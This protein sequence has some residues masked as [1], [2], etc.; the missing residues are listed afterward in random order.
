MNADKAAQAEQIFADA[1]ERAADTRAAYLDRLCAGDDELRAEVDAMLEAAARA[2]S[3]FDRFP[4]RLGIASFL[5]AEAPQAGAVGE[6]NQQFGHYRLIECLG[7]GGMGS[8]W[9]AQ[10]SDGRFEGEVAVK[11][12]ST[13]AGA[14]APERFALEARYLAKLAHP[15]IARLLDAGVGAGNQPYLVLEFVEGAAIDQYC[16]AHYLTVEQRI[17]LFLQVLA[18][19]AHAHAHLIIHRDLKPSNVQASVDGIVK[20]LD[21]GVAKLLDEAASTATADLTRQLGAALTPRIRG[22]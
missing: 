19:V 8:V 21:F 16:D 4:E 11:L 5:D 22:T 20:L 15:N 3:Y 13:A 2:D 18:A 1:L 17:R 7:S 9:R 6:V 10:R 14:A 12:L